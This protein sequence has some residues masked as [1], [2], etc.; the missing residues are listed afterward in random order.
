MQEPQNG[1]Q[2]SIGRIEGTLDSALQLLHDLHI[3][4][5]HIDQRLDTFEQHLTAQDNEIRLLQDWQRH[6]DNVE[7][8][9][10]VT[11]AE[12]QRRILT[13]RDG[14]IVVVVAG[15]WTAVLETVSRA[16]DIARSLHLIR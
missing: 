7:R 14:I 2:R 11:A 5:R 8:A 13:R 6:H 1:M 3:G 12:N 15:L 4:Q 16:E 9:R 10:A